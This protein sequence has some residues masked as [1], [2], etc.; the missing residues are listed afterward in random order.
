[1]KR[2]STIVALLAIL[3]AGCRAEVRMLLDVK[4]SGEG[5]L[6]AEVAID[7]QLEELLTQL[8]GANS[9]DIIARARSG[10]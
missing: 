5:T 3:V 6:T 4:E 9:A 10:S 8:F 1:M 2:L 7:D